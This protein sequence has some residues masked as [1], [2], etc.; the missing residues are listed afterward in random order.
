MSRGTNRPA[1]PMAV[2][3]LVALLC[4]V[5]GLTTSCVGV[6]GV[7]GSTM[8]VS[9]ELTSS[10][11]LFVGNDVGIL[12]VPVG[13][14][15]AIT[16]EGD[17]V[18]VEMEIDTDH[19]IP[20]DVGAVVVARSVA[21]DRYVELT[22]VYTSGPTL[23]DGAV[24]ANDRTR[25]PVEFDQVLAAVRDFATGISGSKRTT[26]AVERFIEVGQK[27]FDGQGS[28][29]NST[30]GS[31]ATATDSV[32]SQRKEIVALIRALDDLVATIA[33]NRRTVDRF[34]GQVS[35]A[36]GQ[37]A[38]E[39]DNLRAALTSLDR[40]VTLVARFAVDNRAT[41]TRS[42][43][44]ATGIIDSVLSRRQQLEEILDVMPAGLQNLQR[45][46]SDGR[47][48]VRISPIYL[49]P[50]SDELTK[51]CEAISKPLCDTLGSVGD[52]LGDILSGVGGLLGGIGGLFGKES[53][54]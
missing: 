44:N 32:S 53:E 25:T 21:T 52:V 31:L 34:I 46:P 30:I 41:I 19:K 5:L 33:D 10:A 14:V 9:A 12:G 40:A 4:G 7:G 18:R 23:A 1:R 38:D 42:M 36:T 43:R 2:A 27:A 20:Q 3:A 17:H 13:T 8:T 16:P 35:S 47:L 29:L 51:L 39:R 24:I 37:L 6:P 11:G 22:P 48:P 26:R 54:R 28:V 15:T 50:L 49:L 45:L